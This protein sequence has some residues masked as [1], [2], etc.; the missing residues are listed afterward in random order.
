MESMRKNIL[1]IL[2]TLLG[3]ALVATVI[4]LAGHA[5]ATPDQVGGGTS[6]YSPWSPS[7]AAVVSTP[8][9]AAPNPA[10]SEPEDGG[11]DSGGDG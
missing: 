7:P 9:P 3:V 11:S 2:L 4:H 6:T 10:A 1:T 8:A 5:T